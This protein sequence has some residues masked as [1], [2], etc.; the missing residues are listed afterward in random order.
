MRDDRFFVLARE[1]FGQFFASESATSDHELRR[2]II[3]V[4]A[5]LL[6]PASF[7][8]LR[9]ARFFEF[10]T[11]RGRNGAA[12]RHRDPRNWLRRQ[13]TFERNSRAIAL[14]SRCWTSAA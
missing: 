7:V 4:L 8:P 14:M 13:W 6:T 1:F 11:A 3:G 12:P 5:F 10:A 2:A 9:L